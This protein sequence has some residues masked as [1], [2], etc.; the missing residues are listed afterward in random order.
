M[1]KRFSINFFNDLQLHWEEITKLKSRV[2]DVVSS[3]SRKSVQ[4]HMS[5][6]VKRQLVTS[7][8]LKAYFEDNKGEK[9]VLRK[10]ID[11]ENET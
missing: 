4:V 9:D 7:K 2:D 8:R 10:S 11:M 1:R 5:N 3:L 6:E